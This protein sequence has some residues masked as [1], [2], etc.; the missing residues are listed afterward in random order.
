MENEQQASAPASCR[1]AFLRPGPGGGGWTRVTHTRAHTH[2]EKTANA[3]RLDDI[4]HDA[5]HVDGGLVGR[6]TRLRPDSRHL[7]ERTSRLWAVEMGG[8]RPKTSELHCRCP[9]T[10]KG[11]FQQAMVPPITPART[12][13]P[14]VSLAVAGL[15]LVERLMTVDAHGQRG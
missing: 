2:L 1:I 8:M 12:S 5:D 13:C 11:W 10:S 14:T 15:S 4:L 6:S 9:L 3:V 7:C